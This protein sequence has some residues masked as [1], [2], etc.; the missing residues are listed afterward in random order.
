MC[1]LRLERE[2]KCSDDPVC[3]LIFYF[4]DCVAVRVVVIFLGR[5]A[6]KSKSEGILP[7]DFKVKSDI[8]SIF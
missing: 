4:N 5:Q 7:A 1:K 8:G 2:N 3:H 6:M